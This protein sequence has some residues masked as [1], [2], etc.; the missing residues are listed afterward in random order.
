M[1]Q[2]ETFNNDELPIDARSSKKIS[3]YRFIVYDNI[4]GYSY[5]QKFAIKVVDKDDNRF[6]L[7]N[8]DGC[9]A[10]LVDSEIQADRLIL[11]F[12]ELETTIGEFK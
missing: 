5:A 7:S 1:N 6:W 12:L 11:N 2:L 10:R 3:G 9:T 8:G 4:K